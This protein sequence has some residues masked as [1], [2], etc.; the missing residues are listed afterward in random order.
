MLALLSSEREM[1]ME[2]NLRQLLFSVLAAVWCLGFYVDGLVS[3]D[4]QMSPE[5][6]NSLQ[7]DAQGRTYVIAG[8]QLLRLS[9]DLQL[10]QNVTLPAIAATISLS[11]DG[12]RLLVCV[13]GMVDR[14]CAVYNTTDLTA[15]PVA[16]GLNLISDANGDTS[17][18][19]AISFS[20]EGSFYVG[21][22]IA[23]STSHSVGL[24]RLS[25]YIHG[26]GSGSP[27]FR[28]KDYDARTTGFL[29]T[30]L[31]GFVDG[32]YAYFVVVDP[33]ADAGFRVL[34]VCHCPGNAATCA[35]TALYEQD[36]VCGSTTSRSG[37]ELLC[38]VSLTDNFGAT[39][40]P[41]MVLSRCRQGRDSDNNVC[42]FNFTAI[43]DNMDMRYDGYRAETILETRVAWDL[44]DMLCRTQTVSLSISYV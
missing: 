17:A 2:L 31:F 5:T 26:D 39:P 34:R 14:S 42:L 16:T 32:T 15:Q 25:Q 41:S 20:T 40:G 33:L 44:N 27:M 12:Q 7:V 19:S 36:I 10:E 6:N 29:R 3:F 22:Y 28:S 43:N 30:F 24:I 9:R 37:K 1:S 13:N 23:V 35:F 11:P 8:S 38:G 18:T 4:L 21:S